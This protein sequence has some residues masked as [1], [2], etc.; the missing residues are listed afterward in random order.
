M[1]PILGFDG[2]MGLPG[3]SGLMPSPM[4]ANSLVVGRDVLL[5]GS[6]MQAF[7]APEPG[8]ESFDERRRLGS[9]AAL[10]F[11]QAVER[12]QPNVRVALVELELCGGLE[13]PAAQAADVVVLDVRGAAAGRPGL[14]FHRPSVELFRQQLLD[15]LA[16][17]DLRL[18][19]S[20][21]VLA[22]VVPQTAAWSAIAGLLPQRHKYTFELLGA[23]LR[24]AMLAVMR[25][26][27]VLGVPRPLEFSPVVQPMILTPG[28]TAFPS[29]HATE[30]YFAAKL[31][32][33]LMAAGLADPAKTAKQR[34]STQSVYW[35]L[36]RL[37]YRVAENRVVA[38]LHF[39]VDSLAGQLLGTWLA[40][41]MADLAGGPR[42]AR[43]GDALGRWEFRAEGGLGARDF[44][45]ELDDDIPAPQRPPGGSLVRGVRLLAGDTSW[46]PQGA[47]P[48]VLR[49]LWSLAC[50]EWR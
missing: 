21:E 23:G 43:S 39:P 29:G 18:E 49:A 5:A 48:S 27:H 33:Q 1:A 40:N 13:W 30:A 11:E 3:Y 2:G 26:K 31:L 47:G 16:Y 42:A 35:Q 6:A 22:Q 8:V 46:P 7:N 34:S 12:L 17:S 15:V 32:P 28:Y 41:Y 50:K 20:A 24:L 45:P 25:L 9:D 38:G 36:H 4:L 10:H 44:R 14:V 19:R 37:A